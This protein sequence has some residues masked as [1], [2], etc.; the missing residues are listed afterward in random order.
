MSL[1][2]AGER[3]AADRAKNLRVYSPSSTLTPRTAAANEPASLIIWLAMMSYIASFNFEK[4]PRF[5]P[6]LPLKRP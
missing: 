1:F 5:L 2:L 3:L 6:F 4:S